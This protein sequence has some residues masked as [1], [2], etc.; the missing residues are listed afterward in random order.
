MTPL[1]TILAWV[2]VVGVGLAVIAV[3][4]LAVIQVGWLIAISIVGFTAWLIWGLAY[5]GS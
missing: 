2:P 5:L 4:V 3:F 1:L